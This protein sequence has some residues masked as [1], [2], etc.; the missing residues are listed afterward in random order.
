MVSLGYTDWKYDY[1]G[2]A[3]WRLYFMERMADL[4]SSLLEDSFY[5]AEVDGVFAARLWF[6]Y[7]RRSGIGNFGHV[8]TE[9][10]FRSKGILNELMSLCIADFNLLRRFFLRVK[11]KT[12]WRSVSMSI[13]DSSGFWATA[14]FRWRS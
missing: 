4:D 3:Y 13:L 5:F 12:P 11:L 9:P 8:F 1:L 6:A 14:V 2:L 7:S 10:Q